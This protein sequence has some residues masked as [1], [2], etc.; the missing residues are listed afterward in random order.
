MFHDQGH[1]PA[2]LTGFDAISAFAVGAGIAF[3]SVGHGS[4]LDIAN[5]SSLIR[6]IERISGAAPPET[7]SMIKNIFINIL[8]ELYD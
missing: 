4:A 7:T 1:I 2:K 6:T 5:P 3:A 8:Y